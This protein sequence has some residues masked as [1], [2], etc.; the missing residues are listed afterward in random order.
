MQDVYRSQLIRDK[1][2]QWSDVNTDFLQSDHSQ[3]RYWS[4]RRFLA[5]SGLPT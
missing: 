3:K 2:Q 1:P 5:L 4:P